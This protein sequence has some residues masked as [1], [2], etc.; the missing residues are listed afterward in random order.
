MAPSLRSS[1]LGVVLAG[2]H[3]TSASANPSSA[4][5]TY[6]DAR[7]AELDAI[8]A[9]RKRALT[10]LTLYVRSRRSAG[11]PARLTFICTH[12]SRRSHMAQLWARAAARRF[13][14]D[15]V[16]TFSGGTEVTAFN[17]RAVAA[18]ERAGLEIEKMTD[19]A[20]PRYRVHLAPDAEP[21]IAYSKVYD[22]EG[23]P[24]SDFAAIM[25]C[26]QADRNC[27]V[28]D[29][30]SLRIAIPYEDPKAFDGTDRE[31]A[32]YDERSAQ[33]AREMLF[34]FSRVEG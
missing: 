31:T 4:V 32:A 15:G 30:A 9:E 34:V 20:N 25:T 21:T 29:G 3:L 10:K 6:L 27:P 2:A 16:A 13:G 5:D 18:L 33:I 12:N 14:I 23:N 1:L 17:P 22:A 11:Q 28:V 8:P 7:E 24:R 26:A 19:G